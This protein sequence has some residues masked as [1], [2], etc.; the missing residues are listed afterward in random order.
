[1]HQ[2]AT[3]LAV[4][5]WIYEALVLERRLVYTVA[6]GS[7]FTP[8]FVHHP[9]LYGRLKQKVWLQLFKLQDS[10]WA[11]MLP[12][13]QSRFANSGLCCQHFVDQICVQLDQLL[14]I[15]NLQSLDFRHQALILG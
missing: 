8:L 12:R 7:P 9:F 10:H 11:E 14:A 1:M 5:I 3:I 6:I 13:P 2:W 4:L 15:I